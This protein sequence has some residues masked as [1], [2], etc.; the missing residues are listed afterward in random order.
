MK[1]TILVDPSLVIITTISSLLPLMMLHTKFGK[2]WHSSFWGKDVNARRTT[3][4]GRRTTDDARRRTPTHSN[5]SP[6][7]LRWPKNRH[8]I[9]TIINYFIRA[10]QIRTPIFFFKSA[11]IQHWIH[12]WCVLFKINI[13][14]PKSRHEWPLPMN[15]LF[16]AS[17]KQYTIYQ[18]ILRI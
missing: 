6:E 18:L 11:R 14:I 16:Q 12:F 2:D 3:N 17:V 15:N 1:Y 9:L 13:H 5:R 4:D 10:R 7:W 8:K